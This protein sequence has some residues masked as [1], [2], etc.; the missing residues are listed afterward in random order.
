MEMTVVVGGMKKHDVERLR[1]IEEQTI[2]LLYLIN[3][4]I[5]LEHKL[6]NEDT[7]DKKVIEEF[8]VSKSRKQDLEELELVMSLIKEYER[9]LNR[10]AEKGMVRSINRNLEVFLKD[11]E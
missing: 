8:W 7:H 2:E 5:K 3:E 1:I 10:F 9:I 11:E 4:R 6:I